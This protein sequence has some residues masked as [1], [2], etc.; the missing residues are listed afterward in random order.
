MVNYQ[1][2]I[3][4][5]FNFIIGTCFSQTKYTVGSNNSDF[6]DVK[7][8]INFLAE[9]T[10]TSRIVVEIEPGEYLNDP[11]FNTFPE[12]NGNSKVNDI[13]FRK[14][15]N[16][17]EEV[18]FR[19]Y[20]YIR[21]N[22]VSFKG[23][24]F[25]TSRTLNLRVRCAK[26]DSEVTFSNCSINSRTNDVEASVELHNAGKILFENCI[27]KTSYRAIR[28]RIR[29]SGDSIFS[30]ELNNNTFDGNFTNTLYLKG[31]NEIILNNNEFRGG[32][33]ERYLTSLSKTLILNGNKFLS[34]EEKPSYLLEQERMS[35]R[36]QVVEDGSYILMKNNFF[37]TR[38]RIYIHF[39]D[40]LDIFNNSFSTSEDS[41]LFLSNWFYGDGEI[42]IVNNVF[43]STYSP[44]LI[45][46]NNHS[47]DLNQI[48]S[49][50]NAYTNDNTY[51]FDWNEHNLQSWQEL[52]GQDIN[53]I[54]VDEVFLSQNDFHTPNAV[55]LNNKGYSLSSV[56]KDI[57]GQIRNMKTP[58]IGADE[59]NLDT[60]TL[61]D[62]EL[63]DI[64]LQESCQPGQP[65]L[66][67]K[68]NSSQEINSFSV[69]YSINN[70][71]QEKHVEYS[72]SLA[73]NEI[74]DVVIED[75]LLKENTLYKNIKF[76]LR[77]PN[78]QRDSNFTN[79]SKEI[80]NFFT[81][82][83]INIHKR[84]NPN[85]T[86]DTYLYVPY[87]TDDIKIIWSTGE[88]KNEIKVTEPGEYS[89]TITSSIDNCSLTK[90]ISIN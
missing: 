17:T 79:S 34:L 55:L 15:P 69:G 14:S 22:F 78:G 61:L 2:K 90:S 57:D 24:S 76:T 25:E 31:V 84:V 73:S 1:K 46:V 53:S 13:L 86:T 6:I 18:I 65:L 89:V 74:K 72:I 12:I 85:C 35:L 45:G 37:S 60:N 47:I 27:F 71:N 63:V 68:N 26:D 87:N 44:I 49:D 33:W 10:I 58:D 43:N 21:A 64:V 83:N 70:N 20:L 56:E 11:N 38:R 80:S 77:K 62:L 48:Q 30:I 50:Y 41:C 52:S 8:A 39:K 66:R 19:N 23:I 54:V 40:K 81:L 16:T 88:T 9:T 42:S 67:I 51:N 32:I 5:L 28:S 75:F 36:I 7:T 4:I 29:E 59:F 3:F 82:S